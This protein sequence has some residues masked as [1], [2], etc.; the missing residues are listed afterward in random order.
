M[1]AKFLEFIVTFGG[2]G[3]IKKAPGTWGSLAGVPVVFLLSQSSPIF[4]MLCVG[5][6]T[7]FSIVVIQAYENLHQNHDSQKIVL[8]EVVGYMIAM[9][10]LPFTW[11]SYL[12]AF[13]LFRFFDILKPFPIGIIDKKVK[14]GLGVV[15]DDVVAGLVSNFILQVV[16]NY[17]SWLGVQLKL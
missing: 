2:V 11:Q 6:L 12:L 9:T 4:Y 5:L 13:V 1:F 17:T 10:W 14:G 16:F 7:L 8:D 15:A 3:L